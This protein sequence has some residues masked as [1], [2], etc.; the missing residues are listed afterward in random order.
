MDHHLNS[1]MTTFADRLKAVRKRMD[2]SQAAFADMAGVSLG[3]QSNYERGEQEPTAAYFLK[4]AQMGVDMDFLF[5][6]IHTDGDEARE[7]ALMNDLFNQMPPAQ[8][9]TAF[10]IM[11]LLAQGNTT[12]SG[13]TSDPK[14]IWRASLLYGQFLGMSEAG[15]NVVECV[16][17]A[18]ANN[19]TSGK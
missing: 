4:L 13:P 2:K 9:A 11:H 18:A 7:V 17:R 16:A 19:G 8:R 14:E 5:G 12:G 1:N 10:A 15:K 6:R 3:S